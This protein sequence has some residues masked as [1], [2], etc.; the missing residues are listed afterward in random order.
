[1]PFFSS[2]FQACARS[3]VNDTVARCASVLLLLWCVG[4]A[5][6]FA[7]GVKLSWDPPTTGSDVSYV[8]QYG[9][10]PGIYP[11]SVPVSFGVTSHQVADLAPGTYY[12]VV[13]AIDRRGVSSTFS[14]AI[15]VDL[16]D[17]SPPP[18]PPPPPP[19]TEEPVDP[20]PDPGSEPPP[21]TRTTLTVSTA[22]ELQDALRTAPSSST[23]LLEPGT[24]ALAEPLA[25]AGVDD[26]EI[27]GRTG[28]REDVTLL[29]PDGWDQPLLSVTRS[30]SFRVADLTIDAG[31]GLA[32]RFGDEVHRP[33]LQRLRVL[34]GG[35]FVLST[36]HASGDGAHEGWITRCRF[37]VPEVVGTLP[38]GIDVRG[39][40]GWVVSDSVF[41]YP[42]SGRMPGS[43]ILMW[44]GAEDSL[45]ER[46]VFVRGA[47]E[48][49]YG[50]DPRRPNQHAGGLV[51]NNMITRAGTSGARGPAI[52]ILD[53]PRAVVAHNSI[54]LSGTSS[55][56]IEFAH[57]DTRYVLIWN[58]LLDGAVRA[59]DGASASR[60][61]NLTTATPAMFVAPAFGD[62]HLRRD[63]AG[64]ALAKGTP[65]TYGPLDIDGHARPSGIAPDLGADQV[66]R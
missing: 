13:R 33:R 23:V 6:G 5:P 26:L 63:N 58:N 35:A 38:V 28:R 34:G 30:D 8:L 39:G 48:I 57:P 24:Y 11:N 4:S 22:Q 50:L 44:Q 2:L 25:V 60:R 65:S 47:R 36:R 20:P 19:P 51:R 59:R 21:S 32:F 41:T 29:A 61:T 46:N 49:V 37:E 45:V 12:F 62:L 9:T 53:A 15:R 7:Q 3:C 55:V 18:P 31:T 27:R 14:N 10:V 1:M 16:G 40:Y 43:A 42:A 17:P 64:A 56:G 54:L 52:S 66:V